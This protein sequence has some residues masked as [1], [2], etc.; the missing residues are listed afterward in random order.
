MLFGRCCIYLCCMSF[1]WQNWNVFDTLVFHPYLWDILRSWNAVIGS[2]AQFIYVYSQSVI[3]LALFAVRERCEIV[4]HP[5]YSADQPLLSPV[6]S[7]F[8]LICLFT[9]VTN[10]SFHRVSNY[11]S[12]GQAV[13]LQWILKWMLVQCDVMTLLCTQVQKDAGLLI[14]IDSNGSAAHSLTAADDS[15]QTKTE[16]TP[17]KRP[18]G[19]PRKYPKPVSIAEQSV[20]YESLSVCCVWPFHCT[21]FHYLHEAANVSF[22]VQFTRENCSFHFGFCLTVLVLCR[23]ETDYN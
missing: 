17:G 1:S 7:Q 13:L 5:D 3:L 22:F 16:P 6:N 15:L 2:T 14:G 18:R 8:C 19:R 11:P 23:V 9:S 20:I 10:Y 21:H 4:D 12:T